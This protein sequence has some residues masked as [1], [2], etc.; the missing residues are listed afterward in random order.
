[1]LIDYLLAVL[2]LPLLLLAWVGVQQAWRRVFPASDGHGDVLVGRVD[3]GQCG[4]ATP[5]RQKQAIN[6]TRRRSQR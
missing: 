1:M 2:L 3:C 6:S 5:C 4:C